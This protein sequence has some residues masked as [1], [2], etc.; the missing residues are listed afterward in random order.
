MYALSVRFKADEEEI[1]LFRVGITADFR[2]LRNIQ[3]L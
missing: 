1:G 3:L 2:K